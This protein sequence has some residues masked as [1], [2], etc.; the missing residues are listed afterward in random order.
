MVKHLP[1]GPLGHASHFSS[2]R[3]TGTQEETEHLC[4]GTKQRSRVEVARKLPA[5]TDMVCG[6]NKG[7][8][9]D[10]V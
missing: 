10:I 7:T 9:R 3:S 4:E 8:G 1:Q 6:M 2:Q 5:R